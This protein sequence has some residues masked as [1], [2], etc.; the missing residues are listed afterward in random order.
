MLYRPRPPQ[1]PLEAAKGNV[2]GGREIARL[3]SAIVEVV[4]V[5]DWVRLMTSLTVMNNGGLCACSSR[6][7]WALTGSVLGNSG[8]NDGRENH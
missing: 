2:V 5:V 7:K 6:F 3:L 8:T 1:Y 4:V